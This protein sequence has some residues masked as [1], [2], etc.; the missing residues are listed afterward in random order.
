[1]PCRPVGDL[2]WRAPQP[3]DRWATVRVAD[4]YGPDCMQIPFKADAAPLGVKPSED[5]ALSQRLDR[6]NGRARNAR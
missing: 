2:R 5:C 4:Q 1:M 6:P 3:A